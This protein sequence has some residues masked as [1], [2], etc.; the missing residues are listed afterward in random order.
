MANTRIDQKTSEKN[1]NEVQNTAPTLPEKPKVESEDGRASVQETSLT[2]NAI[3]SVSKLCVGEDL[4]ALA[5]PNLKGTAVSWDFGDGTI[6]TGTNPSHA[7]VVPG[8]YQIVVSGISGTKRSEQIMSV[9]VNPSPTA[10]MTYERKLE[11]FEA[12]PLYEFNTALLPSETAIWKFSD[13]RLAHGTKVVHL[14]RDGGT[15]KVELTVKNQHGCFSKMESEL[16]TQDFHLL[17]PEAFTPNGD[18][19]NDDFMP[20]ALSTMEVPFTLTIRSMKTGETVYQTRNSHD[21]WNGQLN[22]FGKKCEPG[23]YLWTVVLEENILQ[24]KVFK[25]TVQLKR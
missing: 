24:N 13:G 22:N 3:I 12:I 6:E 23:A 1:T 16:E 9:S 20:E 15:S 18:N 5:T 2:L 19:L 11:S 4:T 10:M 14:F 17:T 7:Y 8:N 25:G 21:R